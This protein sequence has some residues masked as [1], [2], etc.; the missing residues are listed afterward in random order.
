MTDKRTLTLL[1]LI[2]LLALP[3]M[4]PASAGP[5]AKTYTVNSDTD[6]A[7]KKPGDGKCETAGGNCTLHAAIQEANADSDYS[8]INFASQFQG[9][10]AIP[11]CSL[12]GISEDNTTIDASNRWDMTYNRPGVEITGGAC[13]LLTIQASS[14]T[15]LGVFFGGGGTTTG[16]HITGG[17]NNYIGG[18]GE[19]QRNVFLTGR[20]GVWIQSSGTSNYVINN[21]V[22]TVDGETLPGGGMGERGVFVQ[23][24]QSISII[25]NNLIAGQSDAGILLWADSNVVTDNIIGMTWNKA[26]ALPNKVGVYLAGDYNVVG[27]H[28][29]IA[30][31]TS[32]G[33]YVYHADDNTIYH[34]YI[35][36][37]WGIAG[38][39]NGGDGI[40]VHVSS[41]NLINDANVI[42]PN[43]GNGIWVNGSSHTTIQGNGI[44]GNGLDGVYMKSS[45][46]QIGGSGDAL[47]NSIG[48][49]DG[50][51]VHLDSSSNVTVTNN[52]IGLGVGAFDDGNQG[53]G[54]LIDNGSTDNFIGGAGSGE[55]NWIGWNHQDGIHLDGSSTHY[56]FVLGNV[57]GAPINWGWE[58]YNGWHGIGIYGG[59]YDNYIGWDGTPS[60]GNTILSSGWSGVVIVGSND[61]AVLANYIGTNGA[62]V[63]W[64]NAFYG[65]DVVN[66]SGT[67][68]K[69]NEIAYNGTHNGTDGAQAGVHVNGAIAIN[70]MISGNSIHDNDGPGIKLES[71]GNNNLAAP[72][73]TSA[74]C[75]SV[76]GTACANCWI[77]I[78]SDNDDEGQV[79][80]GYFATDPSGNFAWSGALNGPNVTATAIGPGSSKDTSPF[81]TPS[82]IGTCNTPP[83]VTFTVN[84]TTG[85]TTTVFSFD[86]SGCSDAE[87][88]TSALQVRW[89]WDN[90]GTYDT[91]WTT[92]KTESHSYTAVGTY[93][94]RLEVQ[95][96]GGLTDATT[97]QVTVKAPTS[98]TPP[99]ASFTVSPPNGDTSTVFTFDASGSTDAE[100]G[101][102]TEVRWD[103]NNDGIFETNWDTAKT[104]T[105]TF[106][107]AG[108]HTIRLE[109]MDSGG[110]TDATTRQVIVIAETTPAD[111][112]FLPLIVRN[113]P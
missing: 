26:A 44:G 49:N 15:V 34:N 112:I 79:Y 73:I 31:N 11:G 86:G 43:T 64:G 20:Y 80:E 10:H 111:W 7:D 99:K 24:G 27:P 90:N 28:N 106:D 67:S 51:G 16:V 68:I 8:T 25:S 72:V 22:G 100:D 40:H 62:G 91:S 94:V 74:D 9:T 3:V 69:S 37:P 1:I 12:P 55:G 77:E 53:H 102:P 109:V 87:D 46:G 48:G 71:G 32:H 105:H 54:I 83:T 60:G 39:E 35:G 75:G 104:A 103:W 92:T 30:G 76:V 84:P 13:T 98:N 89:D 36:Y 14:T 58:A 17:S 107:T 110:L 18:H 82:P 56:N 65:V 6:A 4:P 47:R 81:S 113:F 101:T 66:S 38:G 85:Y 19:G 78:F 21:Y 45:D 70:N 88:A 29:V 95:D 42:G 41:N 23:A 93:T 97:R 5:Q 2:A 63:N 52:Y 57:I 59:S 96:T 33:V 50:N 61:N 108:T